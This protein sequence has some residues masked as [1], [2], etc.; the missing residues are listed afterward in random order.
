MSDSPLHYSVND[1]HFLHLYSSL[2][3]TE[4]YFVYIYFVMYNNVLLL[5]MFSAMVQNKLLPNL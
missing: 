1:G 3:L 2:Y 5:H 4:I